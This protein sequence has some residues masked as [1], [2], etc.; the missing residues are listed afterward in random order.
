M[1][2]Q[3]MFISLQIIYLYSSSFSFNDNNPL[4]EWLILFIKRKWNWIKKIKY[5][6]Y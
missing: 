4:G 5:I 1:L 3:F 6:K 2:F